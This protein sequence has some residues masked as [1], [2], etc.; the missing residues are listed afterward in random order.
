MVIE[1]Y[2]PREAVPTLPAAEPVTPIRRSWEPRERNVEPC[3]IF[4]SVLEKAK[5]RKEMERLFLASCMTVVAQRLVRF[6]AMIWIRFAHCYQKP[7]V[8]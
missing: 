3:P 4:Q 1:E 5:G 7:H 2:R 8:F 6:Q